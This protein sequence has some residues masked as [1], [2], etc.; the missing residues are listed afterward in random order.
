ME[1]LKEVEIFLCED[2]RTS[3]SLF[4]KYEIFSHYLYICKSKNHGHI[5]IL[6]SN[7]NYSQ[8]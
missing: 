3:K 5:T 6:S 8:N 4:Q 1:L 7:E 2:T